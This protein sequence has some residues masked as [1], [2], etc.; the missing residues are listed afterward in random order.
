CRCGPHGRRAPSAAHR[1]P[2][3]G[4]PGGWAPQRTSCLSGWGRWSCR[5]GSP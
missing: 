5:W 2:A 4:P 3:P 1:P